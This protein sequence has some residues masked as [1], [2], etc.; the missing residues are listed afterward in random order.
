MVRDR[1]IRPPRRRTGVR[2]MPIRRHR[3][4]QYVC[5][6]VAYNFDKVLLG[7]FWGAEVLGVR[8]RVSAGQSAHRKSQFRSFAG[9]ASSPGSSSERP[10]AA[11][12][13]LLKGYSLFLATVVPVT[14]VSAMFADDLV[15]VLLGGK[16][17]ATASLFRLLAPTIVVYA[18]INPCSWLMMATGRTVRSLRIA[19]MIAP[20]VM[21]GYVAG[22]V[23]D[24]TAWR[25]VS[26]QPWCF[27]RHP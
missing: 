13:L 4:A 19:L 6:I 3:D 9:G 14:V 1:L 21:V 16:W 23:T 22:C 7:R 27:W 5:G 15:G 2:S 17:L 12:P 11:P 8:P 20:T 24:R 25:S 18:L 26:R 10:G